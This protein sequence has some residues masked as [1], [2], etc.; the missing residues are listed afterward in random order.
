MLVKYWMNKDVV[1]VD[2]D[3]S[4]QAAISQMR[5]HAKNLLPVLKK[6]NLVG[7]IT[8]R[9]L[10]RASASDATALEIHELAYLISKIK[11]G[12]IMTK[13]VVTVPPDFTLEEASA[14]LLM[15]NISGMPVVDEKGKIVG[16]IS[17][18]EIFLA[19]ISLT[20]FGKKGMQLALEVED[21]PGSIKEITDIIRDYGGRLVSL[22]TSYETAH[23]GHR[24]LY[25]RTWAV[26]RKRVSEMIA[27]LKQ[28]ARLLYIV[29]H[30]EGKREEFVGSSWAA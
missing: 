25:V 21:R 19:L 22:L 1:T 3:D 5:K 13:N 23:P 29:D 28:K 16:T 10:K 7:V 17:Q 12:D 27:D 30:S 8:D 20:G 6:G 2:V 18:Q 15:R 24:R 4:M 11:C 14:Q 26:D 9:D